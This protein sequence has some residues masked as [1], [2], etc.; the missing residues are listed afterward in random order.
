MTAAGTVGPGP[1]RG[2]VHAGIEG[3]VALRTDWLRLLERGAPGGFSVSHSCY[4]ALLHYRHPAPEQVLFFGLRR[5][6]GELQAI[7]PLE[8][9]TRR[10]RRLPFRAWQFPSDPDRPSSGFVVDPGFPAD[11]V[12]PG[13]VTL[14]EQAA[15][16]V[17]VLALDRVEQDSL[18][19]KSARAGRFASRGV[20]LASLIRS[21]LDR[22]G[23]DVLAGR[24]RMFRRNIR[25]GWHRLERLGAVFYRVEREGLGLQEALDA[26]L[27]LERRGWKARDADGRALVLRPEVERHA[28]GMVELLAQKRECEI[29]ALWQGGQCIA[30]MICFI[31]GGELYAFKIASDE[32]YPAMSLGHL[33]I[34]RMLES[35]VSRD[36]ISAV[37]FGWE[38][39]WVAPWGGET[40]EL[41]EIHVGL[42]GLAGRLAMGLLGM[43]SGANDW[44]AGREVPLQ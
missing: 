26:F 39:D 36:N 27:E 42:G 14:L 17:G 8:L 21:T 43:R 23:R 44:P 2:E 16:G 41:W 20:H 28:R 22:P 15:P 6:D 32:H 25:R 19:W 18:T 30:A 33:L 38:A 29:H 3:L 12:L 34:H 35:W 4:E 10:I 13:L 5:A 1:V 11:Q 7:C 37:N 40:T 9:N 31:G 24:S